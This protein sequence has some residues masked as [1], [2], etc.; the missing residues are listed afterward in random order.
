[1]RRRRWGD[2]RVR[3]YVTPVP[4]DSARDANNDRETRNILR[5]DAPGAD[6][7]SVAP[8]YAVEHANTTSNPD[9]GLDDDTATFSSIMH[10]GP[11]TTL[12][13]PDTRAP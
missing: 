4:H 10:P 7:R 12:F 8:R 1:M 9:I 5:D 6:D 11:N 2:R 13:N 3:R